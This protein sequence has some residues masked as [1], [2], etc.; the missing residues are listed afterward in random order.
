MGKVVS[1][2]YPVLDM[3]CAACAQA[4]EKGVKHLRGVEKADVNLALNVLYVDFDKEKISPEKLQKEVQA[5]GYDLIIEEENSFEKQEKEQK[6]HYR[7][8]K[9]RTV[10]AWLFS[11]PVFLLSMGFIHAENA[12]WIMFG[13][14]LPVMLVFGRTFYISG[15]K[16]LIHFRAN[17]DTLVALSTTIAFLF[18]LF[19]TL[20]PEFWMSQNIEPHIY[21]EAVDVVIAFVL[22]GKLMEERAK[23]STTEALKK[24]IGLQARK[25]RVETD[26]GLKIIPVSL[27]KKDMIVSIRPGEKIPV[28]G[29]LTEGSSFVDESMITGEPVAVEKDPGS[30]VYAGT[31]NQ[32]GAFRF[33]ATEVGADTFLSQIIRMVQEA[34]GSKAPVQRLVDK[35]SNIFVPTVIGIAILTCILWMVI[36]GTPYFSY[37]LLSAVSVLVIACPCALGLATP[38]ALMVGIGKGAE[39]HILIKEA[40]ALEQMKRVDT[41]VFDKTGTLTKGRPSVVQLVRMGR[42]ADM[43]M[44]LLYRAEQMSEHPLAE[45]V[46]KYIES[47]GLL[48]YYR[49]DTI[50]DFT[51]VSGKGILFRCGQE[52]YWVGN[53]T[54]LSEQDIP[55]DDATKE[56]IKEWQDDGK[57]IVLFG[58]TKKVWVMAAISDPI[59]PKSVEAIARL[60]EMGIEVCML[61]GDNERTAQAIARQA[62]ID[63]VRA[64]ALPSDKENYVRSLQQEGRVVAMV[65]D[66]INDSQAL[67]VA[68]VSVAMGRGTDVAMSVA[69]M[70]LITSDLTLLPKA[71]ILSK[72]TVACMRR[73]LFWAFIYNVI[74]IPVAAGI[75][76]PLCGFLL[77]PMIAGAAMAFS[78]VSVVL[79]SLRLKRIIL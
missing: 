51:A 42:E 66:G 78:S 67:A 36:G 70:T 8:M 19:N 61:T 56:R 3:H 69:M 32:K 62:G 75:L 64:S 49:N 9:R 1:K 35:I 44:P 20:Y 45:A 24:L 73:N 6:K 52:R 23:G 60:Q 17:M 29:I 10:G 57:S 76:F 40:L 16:Q 37:A 31:I 4:V 39:N 53:E 77:N 72:E 71:I 11:I 47:S 54:L 55:I 33:R 79:N 15:F 59:K 34:Q 30:K 50:E 26:E 21:Y 48:T 58:D 63:R 68:D 18:S 38:T 13:L 41:V 12:N 28:D 27:L 43:V 2:I 5:L 14:T 74:A 46:V 65:G 25:A 22:L 7:Q